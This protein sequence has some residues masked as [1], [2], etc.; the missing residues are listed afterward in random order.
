MC[1]SF[2]YLW[3]DLEIPVGLGQDLFKVYHSH[4]ISAFSVFTHTIGLDIIRLFTM[5]L[6]CIFQGTSTNPVYDRYLM[7]SGEI[8]IIQIFVQYCDGFIYGLSNQVYTGRDVHGFG[9]FNLAGI[10]ALPDFFFPDLSGLFLQKLEILYVYLRTEDSHLDKKLSLI[11][12]QGADSS[13]DPHGMDHDQI[14][15]T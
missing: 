4:T 10:G 7:Q 3:G 14:A 6:H 13:L 2:L 5:G 9:H 1:S 15:D 8:G 11:V 12:G